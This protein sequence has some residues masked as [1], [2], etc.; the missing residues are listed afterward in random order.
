MARGVEVTKNL[1]TRKM[2]G[3]AGEHFALAMLTFHGLRCVKMPDNWPE[4]DLIVE[5]KNVLEKVSVKTRS[6]QSSSYSESSWFGINRNTTAD[7]L[8][9]V[10]MGNEKT[11]E[12]W[13]IPMSIALRA[14]E[15]NIKNNEQE[16]LH[17]SVRTLRTEKFK[18]YEA[19]WYML[20]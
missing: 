6:K 19:N 9:C 7:W 10:L 4:H 13:V 14:A 16:K 12:A 20:I 15:E 1:I 2:L 17:I 3:D 18:K 5:R 11:I 8:I